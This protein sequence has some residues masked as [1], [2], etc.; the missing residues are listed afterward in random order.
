MSF[1]FYIQKQ[2][3]MCCRT[4]THVEIRECKLL[5]KKD[6]LSF[7]PDGGPVAAAVVGKQ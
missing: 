3:S 5:S 4:N 6:Q 2:I 7:P 1:M